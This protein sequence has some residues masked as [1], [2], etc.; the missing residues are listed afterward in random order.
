MPPR[1]HYGHTGQLRS[2]RYLNG[3][4]AEFVEMA[5]LL[6]GAGAQR[7]GSRVIA[8]MF[9]ACDDGNLDGPGTAAAPRRGLR[10]RSD[11]TAVTHGRGT[12]RG[13]GLHAGCCGH[14]RVHHLRVAWL[15]AALVAGRPSAP[16]HG[17]TGGR[18]GSA[19]C[20]G[21]IDD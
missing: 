6:L 10:V 11:T 14:H 19:Q 7:L 8:S 5:G 2:E 13:T 21:G 20:H 16:V 15:V 1:A 9:A 12:A 18:Q 3:T 17:T 4:S